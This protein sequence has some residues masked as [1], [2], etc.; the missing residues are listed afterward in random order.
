VFRTC[1]E[2]LRSAVEVSGHVLLLL[3][4]LLAGLTLLVGRELGL[5]RVFFWRQDLNLQSGLRLLAE[6]L[7]GLRSL[8]HCTCA[9]SFD[10][11]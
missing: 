5:G 7:R 4:A 6:G 11:V 8:V 1:L 3:L 2:A 10:C 9:L